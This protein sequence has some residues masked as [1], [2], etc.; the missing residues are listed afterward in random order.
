MKIKKIYCNEMVP[1]PRRVLSM[2]SYKGLDVDIENIDFFERQQLTPEFLAVNPEGTIPVLILEDGTQFTETTPM[3][4]LIDE[5]Y[6]EKP[7]FGA[8]T[9]EKIQILSWMNKIGAQSFG[10]IAEFLRNSHPLFESRALSGT[11]EVQ[12]IPELAVRGKER[13][14]FFWDVANAALEGKSF[15]VGDTISQADI[16]LMVMTTFSQMA[17]AEPKAGTHDALIAHTARVQELIK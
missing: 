16:D 14:G 4:Q 2:V 1:N 8:N 9:I 17:E 15:L 5:L 13:I 11:R 12:Q 3:L 10:P 6:P 7:L